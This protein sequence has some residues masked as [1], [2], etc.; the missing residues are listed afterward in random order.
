MA[1]CVPEGR[2]CTWACPPSSLILLPIVLLP[3]QPEVSI[4]VIPGMG[5]TQRLARAVGKSRA[6]ELILTG[7][8]PLRCVVWVGRWG[9][10]GVAVGG[11]GQW[12]RGGSDPHRFSVCY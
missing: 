2:A 7:D 9:Q 11:G 5:G 1:A 12:P 4:G 6:M 10:G 8:R 3:T